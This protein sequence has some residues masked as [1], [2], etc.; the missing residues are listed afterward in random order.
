MAVL[1]SCSDIDEDYRCSC[2]CCLWTWRWARRRHRGQFSGFGLRRQERWKQA[3][4]TGQET[5]FTCPK[6]NKICPEWQI[7]QTNPCARHRAHVDKWS[8]IG[9]KVWRSSRSSWPS[10]TAHKSAIL[11][12][13]GLDSQ[14]GGRA[15]NEVSRG[16]A[17]LEWEKKKS[18][19]EIGL[20]K[21]KL[22]PTAT[23]GE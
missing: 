5:V 22:K 6:G 19:D 17:I 14:C 11:H 8:T 20:E 15:C 4:Q 18:G 21:R 23:A 2:C 3:M 7:S 1:P 12:K 13:S 16:W 9:C 10:R